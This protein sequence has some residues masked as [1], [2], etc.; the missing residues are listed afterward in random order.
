MPFL[1]VHSSLPLILIIVIGE[2]FIFLLNYILLRNKHKITIFQ[3]L[4]DKFQK[5]RA[6]PQTVGIV[7][8]FLTYLLAVF[9]IFVIPEPL[10]YRGCK[11][12]SKAE[13]QICR[14]DYFI[15]EVI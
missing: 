2:A 7:V 1:R 5:N 15:F 11:N 14:K 10:L 8:I 6:V 4:L 3:T 13:V 9:S 12:I